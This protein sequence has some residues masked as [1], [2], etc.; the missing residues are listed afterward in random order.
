MYRDLKPENILIDRDGHV[1]ITDFGLSKEIDQEEGT[2]TF[3]ECDTFQN[4]FLV[5]QS[6]I[7]G[8]PEYLA[9]EVLKGEGHGMGVDWWSLG[10]LLFEMMTGLPPFFSQNINVMYQVSLLLGF[11]LL[12]LTYLL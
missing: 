11:L 2:H 4:S 5:A 6:C 9:P 10:T 3:C 12:L 8:T 7:G 1:V